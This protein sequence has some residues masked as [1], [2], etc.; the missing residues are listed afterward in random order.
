M[1]VGY[2]RVSTK[3]QKLALQV[4]ALKKAGCSKVYTEVMSGA[5]ADRPIL[6]DLLKNLRAGDVVVIWKLDR[7]G[8]SLR[9]LVDLVNE[10]MTR[11]VGLKSLNDPI[12]TTTSHGRLTFNLFASLA[13]FER[14]VIR[15]RTQAGLTAARARGRLGGRPPGITSQAESTA[16]A[17]EALY[18]EGKLS[19][20]GIAGKLQIAKSTLYAYLRHRGVPIGPYRR[21]RDTVRRKVAS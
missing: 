17:A 6:A 7:L 10:L 11:K 8:R 15:E 3:D 2:A 19:A 21:D 5:R 20:Q 1:K 4:D 14:D 13:E 9:H 16:Y 12:D 18:R